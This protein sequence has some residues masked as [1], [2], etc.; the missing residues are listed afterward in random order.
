MESGYS[1]TRNCYKQNWE[2][3]ASIYIEACKSFQV[4]GWIC[5]K[6]SDNCCYDHKDQQV[7]VQVITWLKQHRYRCDTGNQNVNKDQD[8]PCLS[9]QIH[10]EIKSKCYRCNKHN[11]CN[12]CVNPFIQF[13]IFQNT[14]KCYRFYNEKHGCCRNSTICCYFTYNSGI[15]SYESVECSCNYI[16]KCSNNKNTE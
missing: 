6:Y 3:I 8:M 10:W 1:S 14:A 15:I 12:C 9:C 5:Y 11:N 2:H 7:T 13:S 16:R 4:T